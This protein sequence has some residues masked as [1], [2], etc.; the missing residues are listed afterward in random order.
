MKG[1]VLFSDGSYALRDVPEPAIGGN[2][3]APQDVLIEVAYCGI[4]GSDVHKWK[5]SDKQGVSS[6]TSAVVT[7]HEI[8]GTVK[9]VGPEVSEIAVGD[10]VVCELVTF[11]CG[12]C[13]NCQTGRI[14]ICCNMPSMQQRAHYV[15]GGGYA[16]YTVWPARHVHVLPP[17]ISLEEGTMI[18]PTAG[19]VH[20]LIERMQVRA[21]ESV[22]ILGPGARGLILL[23]I[24]KAC[25]ASPVAITGLGRDEKTR[26]ALARQLGADAVINVEKE[27]LPSRVRELTGGIGFDVVIE[28]TGAASAVEQTLDLARNG[29]RILI[30]GGGI[31]G[32]ILA[33]LDTRKIIVKE[34]ELS[35]EIS[36]VWTSWKTAIKLVAQ[37]KVKLRPLVSHVFP[38]ERWEEAFDL[39]ATSPDALRVAINPRL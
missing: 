32:G 16:R 12:R 9:A 34:L 25:G 27:D 18:E 2:V 7:G 11:Y 30:S 28:N 38:L 19:S 20:S 31:R 13:I 35:G 29:G 15:T 21:G 37:G 1:L 22:I 26:L 33:R 6:P 8:V 14:N 39:A 10:R 4:C 3:Y 17:E 23:Q 5:D 36:H 24:A